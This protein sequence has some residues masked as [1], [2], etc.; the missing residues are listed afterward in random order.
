MRNFFSRITNLMFVII[1]LTTL[2]ILH[3]SKN[4]LHPFFI[5]RLKFCFDL[6]P[7]RPRSPKWKSINRE[8]GTAVS[9]RENPSRDAKIDTH[10][11]SIVHHRNNLIPSLSNIPISLPTLSTKSFPWKKEIKNKKPK[12]KK[13]KN[14]KARTKTKRSKNKKEG[15]GK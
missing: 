14:F 5:T 3:P 9:Q 15:R 12:K 8:N 6:P 2:P 11:A 7:Y 13:R 10:D 4:F 1:R